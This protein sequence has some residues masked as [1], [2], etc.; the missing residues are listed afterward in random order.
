ML[1]PYDEDDEGELEL[2]AKLVEQVER[3]VPE[4]DLTGSPW[5]TTNDTEQFAFVPRTS[6]EFTR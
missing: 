3:G 6:D 1:V 2:E 5:H 4:N